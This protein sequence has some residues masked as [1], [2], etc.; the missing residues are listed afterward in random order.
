MSNR[1]REKL[2]RTQIAVNNFRV[3]KKK[4]NYQEQ[5]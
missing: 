5:N 4:K 1:E 3:I 2:H